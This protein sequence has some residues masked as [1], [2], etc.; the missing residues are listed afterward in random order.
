[1]YNRPIL[2]FEEWSYKHMKHTVPHDELEERHNELVE[3]H[4]IILNTASTG[5]F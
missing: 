5:R 4:R 2:N 1:M 3:R